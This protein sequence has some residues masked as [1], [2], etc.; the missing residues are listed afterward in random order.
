MK[1][2]NKEIIIGIALAIFIF[3]F[4]TPVTATSFSGGSGTE[5]DPWQIA[6]SQDFDDIRNYPNS[7]FIQVDD[8]DLGIFTPI[9]SFTG[10]YKGNGFS[11]TAEISV[12]G[13][14][15]LFASSNGTLT[16][17]RVIGSS[18]GG[19]GATGAIV[20]WNDGE[21]LSCSVYGTNVNGDYYTGGIVGVN[22]GTI[23][24]SYVKNSFITGYQMI[25]GISGDNFGTIKNSYTN[26]STL[27]EGESFIGG[28]VSENFGLI[29]DCY[30]AAEVVGIEVEPPPTISGRVEERLN[31][32]A[33]THVVNSI[34]GLIGNCAGT[35]I[36]SYWDT[37]TSGQSNSAGGEGRTTGEMT[38]P[39]AVNTYVDWD[40]DS[41]WRGDKFSSEND[42][43]PYHR[44][45]CRLLMMVARNDQDKVW[46]HKLFYK[47]SWSELQSQGN[48]HDNP[49]GWGVAYYEPGYFTTGEGEVYY[50]DS[51][52]VYSNRYA[53]H[54]AADGDDKFDSAFGDIINNS[55]IILAHVRY[56]TSGTTEP[57]PNPHPFVF[58]KT[59]QYRSQSFTFAH[60][61]GVDSGSV[62]NDMRDFILNQQWNDPQWE[63]FAEHDVD[64]GRYF[65]F[66]MAH[67]KLNDWDILRGLRAA[68]SD[69]LIQN[70][71]WSGRNFIFSDGYDGY[72]Y[73]SIGSGT[74]IGDYTL[75]YQDFTHTNM[76]SVRIMS[77]MS[78]A[79]PR[80]THSPIIDLK[81]DEL[82]YF[83]RTGEIQHFRNFHFSSSVRWQKKPV[84]SPWTT[85]DASYT[86]DSFPILD[87]NHSAIQ[88][89]GTEDDFKHAVK[90]RNHPGENIFINHLGDW[91]S[92]RLDAFY[93]TEGYIMK[94][95]TSNPAD[96]LSGWI[97]GEICEPDTIAL[98]PG[99]DN[100][101]GYYLLNN[102]SLQGA[103]GSS[104]RDRIHSVRSSNWFWLNDRTSEFYS[105]RHPMEFGQM[106]IVTLKEGEAEFEDF[107]W[108]NSRKPTYSLPDEE[109][110]PPT[111]PVP[112]L[113]SFD[114][115]SDYQVIEV[116]YLEEHSP[117]LEVGVRPEPG[118]YSSYIG[119]A[120]YDTDPFQI[121]VNGEGVEG[122]DLE[123]WYLDGNQ[124][125]ATPQ[126]IE[127]YDLKTEKWEPV[128]PGDLTA[129][130][131]QY[132]IIR[133][134][135]FYEPPGGGGPT[136]MTGGAS[137][138]PFNPDVTLSFS[139]RERQD[140]EI[141]VFNIRGQRV[142]TLA[143][144]EYEPGSYSV[145]WQGRNENNQAV[146]SGV[147]F[148]RITAGKESITGKMLMLK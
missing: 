100:W 111:W 66:I 53:S 38:Y 57:V 109:D 113:L 6:T 41:V 138:N 80:W 75:Q 20:A 125:Y 36:N 147:Y 4:V 72:A 105:K 22:D 97:T 82:V 68:L 148:Y 115:G 69:P 10:T 81:E 30:S 99:Q 107:Q 78:G 122:V 9:A 43:Y 21:L 112:S 16:K 94:H 106:Y 91:Q 51:S 70:N 59:T 127:W 19:Q 134:T 74:P 25:G 64:S 54:E 11:I 14:A 29:E 84:R 135:G 114:K 24:E 132:H 50:P 110:S 123:L 39:Y 63:V 27:I 136:N 130:N 42:G 15:G 58:T 79:E 56:R 87:P 124:E 88:T 104:Q 120:V 121:I 55:K 133:I 126:T 85:I 143:R 37:E 146:G 103:L 65:G 131:G 48:E 35:V 96:T 45:E 46:D 73:R 5:E 83:P 13:D 144:G 47:S 90:V 67:I 142:K 71:H 12:S 95:E 141:T 52:T 61:G 140:V 8:V 40:F 102:Q 116:H 89:M 77:D 93:S 34:G 76:P 7:A 117:I 118:E 49:H 119:G 137:P 23:K 92:D 26:P 145:V 1:I 139:I 17:I 128:G 18:I 60:N 86:W 129:G 44:H 2:I 32:S 98:Q 31:K 33:R 108:V 28:L 62:L 3:A 101:A